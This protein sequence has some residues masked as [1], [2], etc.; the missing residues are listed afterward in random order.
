MTAKEAPT[1]AN[2]GTNRNFSDNQAQTPAPRVAVWL[3]R[4]CGR[5]SATL[6]GTGTATAAG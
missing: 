4:D 1:K 3:A 2:E 6:T 5:R